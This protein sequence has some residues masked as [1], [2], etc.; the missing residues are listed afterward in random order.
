LAILRISS[1]QIITEILNITGFSTSADAPWGSDA[2]LL[3]KINLNAQKIP[4]KLRQLAMAEGKVGRG[5]IPMWWTTADS[6]TSSGDGDF[7]VTSATA[8]G[9]LPANFDLAISL[10]DTTHNRFVKIIDTFA[11][12]SYRRWREA[13]PGPTKAMQLQGWNETAKRQFRLLPDVASGVTPGLRMEYY[14]LPATMA[15]SSSSVFPDGDY[16]YHYLWILETVLDVLRHDDPSYDRY[17]ELEKAMLAEMS[18][19]LRAA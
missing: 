2:N 11:T 16:K 19:Y 9:S 4:Q 6:T 1:E 13:S 3:V 15:T 8:T 12:A 18:S 17:L 10:Y 5:G 14:R 7:T